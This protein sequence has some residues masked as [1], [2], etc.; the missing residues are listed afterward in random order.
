M[1]K[2]FQA[3][4]TAYTEAKAVSGLAAGRTPHQG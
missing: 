4:L 3:A 1:S 2:K